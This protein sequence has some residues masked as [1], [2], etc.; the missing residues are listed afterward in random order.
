MDVKSP[1]LNE[2][3]KEVVYIEQPKGYE[4]P[5]FRNHVIRLKKS[6]Y[7]LKQDPYTWYE[8]LTITLLSNG[9]LKGGGHK[10]SF[11]SRIQG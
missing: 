7:D 2:V 3:I 9:F 11:V 4:N 6:L 5:H 10:T 8:H 1:F